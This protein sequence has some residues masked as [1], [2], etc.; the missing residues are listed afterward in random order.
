MEPIEIIHGRKSMRKIILCNVCF[1][2]NENNI[3]FWNGIAKWE[4]S[5]FSAIDSQVD[6]NTVFLD[7]GAWI[8]PIT[9]YAASKA[10]R[11]I[12][13]EPDPVAA[14]QLREN[15]ML[16]PSL[17]PKISIEERAVSPESGAVTMGARRAQGDSM[18]SVLHV[19][20]KI[21]WKVESVTPNDIA[22]LIPLDAPVFL[23]MDIEGAEYKLAPGLKP[24][25]S[26]PKVAVLISFHPHFAVPGHPRWHKTFPMTQRV[27]DVFR[28]FSIYRVDRHPLRRAQIVERLSMLSATYFEARHAWLFVK[29]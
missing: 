26:R 6:H 25:L 22:Q 14:A 19:N 23:K 7:F 24:L 27:F 11:V 15:V 3:D 8:G 21:Q 2:V 10:R 28:G 17:A 20:S 4:K 12:S 29:K 5:T 13:F 18:S 1:N 16:N 9:L